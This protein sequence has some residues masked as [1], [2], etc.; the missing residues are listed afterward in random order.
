MKKLTSKYMTRRKLLQLMGLGALTS[1]F[2]ASLAPLL[3]MNTANASSSNPHRFLQIFMNGGW[4]A[5]LST[6]PAIGGKANSINYDRS[7]WD[8]GFSGYIGGNAYSIGGST[9]PNLSVG[10]GLGSDL[11]NFSPF[12]N[13]PTTFVNGIFVEVTAHELAANYLYS[14]KLSLSRSK[15]YP[16]IIATMADK[17]GGFPA[18]VLF[19]TPIPLSDTKLTNPPLQAI[20]IDMLNMMLGGPRTP[21]WVGDTILSDE[22]IESS[23]GLLNLLDN[24][25]AAR[26]LKNQ[27]SSLQA[28]NNANAG[29]EDFYAADFTSKMDITALKGPF[30]FSSLS[31]DEAKFAAAFRA[32]ESNLSRF[33]TVNV[34]GFDTHQ[35]HAATHI[36]IMQKTN[37]SLHNLIEYLRTTTDTHPGSQS[38]DKLIDNTTILITS[39]FNRTPLFNSSSGTDHWTTTNA[40]LMGRGVKP[41]NVFG[42]TNNAGLSLD[43]TGSSI[44]TSSNDSNVILPDHICS[45]ILRHM[46]FTEEA[47]E[48]TKDDISANIFL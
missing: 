48:L 16:A 26:R 23:H 27:E 41:D 4:D 44:I 1:P 43:R 36:P 8:N 39:E 46:G 19:G 37:R 30:G 21:E 9:N 38:G 42:T 20:S 32:I 11:V 45:A 6:D 47:D 24:Q 18:H 5:A 33:I 22:A 12:K 3:T 29:V 10:Y 35:N 15:E 34:D 31:S 40:I 13:V 28:W 17:V 25:Y 14:G 7:Y 2:S